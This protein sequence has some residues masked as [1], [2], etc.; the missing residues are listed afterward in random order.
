V[1]SQPAGHAAGD[2]ALPASASEPRLPSIVPGWP[3]GARTRALAAAAATVLA[4]LAAY[5]FLRLQVHYVGKEEAGLQL[6]RWTQLIADG[7]GLRTSAGPWA[8]AVL[9]L[10]TAR[11]V[12]SGPPEPP[13]GQAGEQTAS[14]AEMRRGLRTELHGMRW[15]LLGLAV[16]AGFDCARVVVDLVWA[17]WRSSPVARDQLGWT[18]IEAAG[19]AIAAVS[20]GVATYAFRR[21]VR[22][23]GAL[24]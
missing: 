15:V 16:L 12:L 10:L 22:D 7:S 19:L 6:S 24:G 3:R 14:A 11:R 21:Q 5:G 23:L 20:L 13:L 1:T 17:T 9:F 2:P 18:A 8:A 4:L